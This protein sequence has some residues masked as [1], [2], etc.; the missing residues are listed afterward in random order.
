MNVRIKLLHP[1]AKM[2]IKKH[3]SDFCYDV[4]AC[5]D[6]EPVTDEEGNVIPDVYRYHTGLSFEIERAKEV[7]SKVKFA[8]DARPRSSIYKTGLVLSNSV[9]TIDEDYRGEMQMIF[10]HVNPRLPIYKKGDRICQIKI[11]CTYD[12]HFIEVNE[13][14]DT[15]RAQGGFGSTGK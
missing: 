15:D 13:L 14:S 10:Y 8:I 11:G 1:D 6:A 3:D 5:S 9:G 7:P 12:L 2:P 4:Y